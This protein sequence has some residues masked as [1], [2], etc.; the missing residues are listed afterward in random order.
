MNILTIIILTYLVIETLL[1]AKRG[2]FKSVFSVLALAL[3]MFFASQCV[4]QTARFIKENTDF[5]DVIEQRIAE[6]LEEG[7]ASEDTAEDDIENDIES[8]SFQKQLLE[9]SGFSSYIQDILGNN[10][11]NE[12]FEALGVNNFYEYIASYFT[13]IVINILSFLLTFFGLWILFLIIGKAVGEVL[14]IP[15]L[16]GL[17]RFGGALFG[18]CKGFLMVLVF[19]LIITMFGNSEWA[20]QVVLLIEDSPL[21]FWIYK[22][23]PLMEIVLDI[24]KLI[25]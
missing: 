5:Y 11:N 3:A 20:K 24:T 15:I 13:G 12:F 8:R 14:N 7:V 6:A 21:M 2:F 1:G 19:F 16:R 17:N 22:N 18:I 9:D 25:F 23:N 10:S 4:T